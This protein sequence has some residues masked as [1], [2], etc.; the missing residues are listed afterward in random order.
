MDYVDKLEKDLLERHA[1]KTLDDQFQG[2]TCKTS[3]GS[4]YRIEDSTKFKIKC[5]NKN[6]AESTILSDLKL[7]K[8]IGN[9]KERILKSQGFETIE[10]LLEHPSYSKQARDLID[11][12]E[13]SPIN[14]LTEYYS[15]SHPNILF[16]S[17]YKEVGDFLFFDIETLGLK[18]RPVILIGQAHFKGEDII[19]T[20]YLARDLDDEKNMI[21]SF[22]ENTGPETVFVSFNGRSFDLPFIRGRARLHG[23]NRR[24]NQHHLDL[25]HLSRR[26]WGDCLPNCRLQ[27]IEKHLFNLERYEDVPSSHVPAFYKTYMK[28]GNIGPLVPIVEHNK[29]DV[30]TLA[31]ILS[32]LQEEIE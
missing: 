7:I 8:G 1:G 31:W 12:L 28:T 9:A 6:K 22:M 15:G 32:R 17:S 14:C 30:I 21:S 18:D 19:V 16:S 25:L 2:E 23:L 26:T 10:N 13:E 5:I 3:K 11:K 20:Q 24:L 27:T 29:Q 4:C